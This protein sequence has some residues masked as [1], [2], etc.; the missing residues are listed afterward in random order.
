MLL[1]GL[2]QGRQP[3]L[4]GIA[5]AMTLPELFCLYSEQ[6]DLPRRH[7]RQYQLGKAE[8]VFDSPAVGCSR[9]ARLAGDHLR[10]D[11]LHGPRRSTRGHRVD[12]YRSIDVSEKLDH[13]QAGTFDA[14]DADIGSAGG[15]T[16]ERFPQSHGLQASRVVA[17][18]AL[19]DSDHRYGHASSCGSTVSLRKCVAQEMQGS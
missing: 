17:P 15:L 2:A 16:M 14:R 12:E 18:Q 6:T 13:L 7:L 11:D 1:D 19:P 10:G 4:N 5:Q 3:I 9:V 8:N